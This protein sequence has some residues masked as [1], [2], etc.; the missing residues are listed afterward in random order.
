M[1][2]S[3][4]R[5]LHSDLNE[6]LSNITDGQGHHMRPQRGNRALDIQNNF[7]RLQRL[8]ALKGFY[9]SYPLKYWDARY[10]FYRNNNYRWTPW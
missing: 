7:T 6:H 2:E 1:S 8:S 10:D 5:D 3:R 9:D 4:H